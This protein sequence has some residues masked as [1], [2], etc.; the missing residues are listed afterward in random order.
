MNGWLVLAFWFI[1]IVG[2]LVV[3]D[4]VMNHIAF[5]EDDE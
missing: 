1:L 3:I 5:K 4:M 2:G